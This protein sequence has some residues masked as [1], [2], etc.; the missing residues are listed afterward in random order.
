MSLSRHARWAASTFF[1]AFASAMWLLLAYTRLRAPSAMSVLLAAQSLLAAGRLVFR[2]AEKVN[3]PFHWKVV[4]WGS[5]LLPLT[6]SG[7]PAAPGWR[8]LPGLLL[9][10][11]GLLFALW[12]LWSLGPAFGIAPAD[13]GLVTAGPYRWVR[14]P[15]YAGEM[16]SI[17]GY[18]LAHPSP[19]NGA[20]WLALAATILLRA[21]WEERV[22]EGYARYAQQVRWRLLPGVW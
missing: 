5:A 21:R 1:T 22:I 8:E 3:A 12:A 10:I 17:L 15:A 7:S 9:Q 6:L 4:A 19:W 14:H 11:G 13:R 2:R 16:V 18:V 20:M